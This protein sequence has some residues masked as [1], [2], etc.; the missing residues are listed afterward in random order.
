[1]SMSAELAVGWC[2]RCRAA[3]RIGGTCVSCG[4]TPLDGVR[5]NRRATAPRVW[6][7]RLK[8]TAWAWWVAYMV[9]VLVIV[10]MVAVAIFGL[11]AW[12]AR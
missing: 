6:W 4:R 7:W 1:M 2:S 8:R 10:A 5:E 9:P 11:V 3:T 12:G